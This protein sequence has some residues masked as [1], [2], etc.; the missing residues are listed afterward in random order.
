MQLT[1]A[2]T[3]KDLHLTSLLFLFRKPVNAVN[4][5]VCFFKPQLIIVQRKL[6]SNSIMELKFDAN[7]NCMNSIVQGEGSVKDER[8][9]FLKS[10]LNLMQAELFLTP[11]RLMLEA[12]ANGV[13]GFGL[14]GALL[15]KKAEQKD[16]GFNIPIKEIIK[17]EEGRHGLQKN[18]LEITVSSGKTYRMMVKDF[19]E[20][21]MEINR[22]RKK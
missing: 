21:E 18:I 4:I 11:N 22:I 17:V 7:K 15:R 12:H 10:K 14:L 5:L 13:A 1:A 19:K 3:V 9:G 6:N 8:V 16:H 2:G 20:W